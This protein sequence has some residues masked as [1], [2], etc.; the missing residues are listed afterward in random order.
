MQHIQT[1]T[2][3]TQAAFLDPLV[4]VSMWLCEEGARRFLVVM[5]DLRRYQHGEGF[6][7]GEWSHVVPAADAFS[8][9]CALADK[10]RADAT[11][12][13]VEAAYLR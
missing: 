8:A 9:V 1:T 5:T 3:T 2:I 6:I 7:V 10:H 13:A 12:E 4:E 11:V